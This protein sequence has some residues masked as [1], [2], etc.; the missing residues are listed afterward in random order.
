MAGYLCTGYL[1]WEAYAN[2]IVRTFLKEDTAGI[3]RPTLGSAEGARRGPERTTTDPAKEGGGLGVDRLGRRFTW[4]CLWELEWWNGRKGE[5]SESVI[6]TRR[7]V[8]EARAGHGPE[9]V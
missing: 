3:E 8:P 7:T 5:G 1:Q 9:A 2:P 4:W 6:S